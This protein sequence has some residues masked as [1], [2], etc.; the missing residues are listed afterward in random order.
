MNVLHVFVIA[1][2]LWVIAA[3]FIILSNA[4]SRR[5]LKKEINN[6]IEFQNNHND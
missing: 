5:R 6:L 1:S 3:A 2:V 4:Y